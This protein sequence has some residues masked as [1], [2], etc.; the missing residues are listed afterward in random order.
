[1]NTTL[2]IALGGAAGAAARHAI[3]SRIGPGSGAGFPWG[4]FVVNVSGCALMGALGAAFATIW[5]E[6][7]QWRAALVIGVLGG[8]TTFSAFA[9]DALRLWRDGHQAQAA[10]Y[11]AGTNAA[12]LL[13]V[14]LGAW[15]AGAL[16]PRPTTS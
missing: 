5:T 13:G 14:W 1:M 12:C 11:V 6:R 15:G 7:E 16:S 10:L 8:Y 2:L 4:V 3:A 9:W